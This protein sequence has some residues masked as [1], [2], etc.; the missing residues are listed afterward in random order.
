MKK[1]TQFTYLQGR[2]LSK[3][4]IFEEKRRK[5]LYISRNPDPALLKK[6]KSVSCSSPPALQRGSKKRKREKED[7]TGLIHCQKIKKGKCPPRSGIQRQSD[8]SM[9]KKIHDQHQHHIKDKHKHNNTRFSLSC[10]QIPSF[11]SFKTWYVKVW[12][13]HK[14]CQKGVT[15]SFENGTWEKSDGLSRREDVWEMGVNVFEMKQLSFFCD[16]IFLGFLSLSSLSRLFC[17]IYPASHLLHIC[18]GG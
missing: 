3:P 9:E 6:E 11:F 16:H 4:S 17:L 2:N 13:S 14:R 1:R 7:P 5:I 15:W 10:S 8:R 18:L 12:R